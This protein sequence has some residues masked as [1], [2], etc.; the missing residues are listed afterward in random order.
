MEL[1][2]SWFRILKTIS[3]IAQFSNSNVA[4]TPQNF[5]PASTSLLEQVYGVV[6]MVVAIFEFENS[7]INKIL[8]LTAY[9][10]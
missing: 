2:P 7:A 9:F 8:L 1:W 10:R 3:V 5:P 4:N 6:V